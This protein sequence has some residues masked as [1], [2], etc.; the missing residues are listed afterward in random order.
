MLTIYNLQQ[1]CHENQGECCVPTPYESL[2]RITL[3]QLISGEKRGVSTIEGTTYEVVNTRSGAS[4]IKITDV[5]RLVHL[6]PTLLVRHPM[7]R[8]W[9]IEKLHIILCHNR[10]VPATNGPFLD[11]LI[12]LERQF[13]RPVSTE[14]TREFSSCML[15]I[16]DSRILTRQHLAINSPFVQ[17]MAEPPALDTWAETDIVNFV[18]KVKRGPV[19]SEAL[20]KEPDPASRISVFGVTADIGEHAI[21]CPERQITFS[22]LPPQFTMVVDSLRFTYNVGHPLH[23]QPDDFLQQ[24]LD[25]IQPHIQ[26]LDRIFIECAHTIENFFGVVWSAKE[27][28]LLTHV[29]LQEKEKNS[30]ILPMVGIYSRDVARKGLKGFSF[31]DLRRSKIY[32]IPPEN[33]RERYPSI[34]AIMGRLPSPAE[35]ATYISQ[36][37]AASGSPVPSSSVEQK[38]R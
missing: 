35:V 37:R 5:D 32:G 30:F 23:K 6:E 20:T 33:Y 7:A 34:A 12:A 17:N 27:M 26:P 18:S 31:G 1:T 15:Q 14:T 19:V 2:D 24:R 22:N 28:V 16:P 38:T 25:Q 3:S 9:S 4:C 8:Q 21:L 11:F 29:L 10:K 36:T 13:G